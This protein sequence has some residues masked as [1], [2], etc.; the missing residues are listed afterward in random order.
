MFNPD[1]PKAVFDYF[2]QYG[3]PLLM[4]ALVLVVG[5]FLSRWLSRLVSRAIPARRPFDET[6]RPLTAQLVRYG[7]FILA[8]VIALGE[9]GV[10]TT[11]IL[12]VLGAAGLAVALALQDTLK[13]LAAGIMLIWLRPLQAGEYIDAEGIAG[14]V[15]EIG[16]FAT[17]LRNAEGVYVFTP[18]HKIWDA[19]ITNY[20]RD[21]TRRFDLIIGISHGADLARAR[22]VLVEIAEAEPRVLKDPAPMVYVNNLA[23]ASVEV[24]LRVWAKTEDYWDTRFALSEK[25]KLG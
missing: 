16:L 18:N 12:A 13:N 14:T 10:Q 17:Q 20:S 3:P 5:W 23:P 15:V 22:K 4:A 19:T 25:A 21:K 7:V 8:I 9:L 1:F 24:M 2:A 6:V 11:S